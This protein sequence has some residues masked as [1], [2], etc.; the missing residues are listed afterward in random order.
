MNKDYILKGKTPEFTGA[1]EKLKY[2]WDEFVEYKKLEEAK[3]RSAIIK[4]NAA[5]KEYHSSMGSGDYRATKPKLEKDENDLLEKGIIPETQGWAERAKLWFYGHG[6]KLHPETGKCIFTKAQ[7]ATP[8][9]ELQKIMEEVEA[10]E[11]HQTERRTSCHAP[12]GIQN[13]VDE[14]E[15]QKDPFR[16][17]MGFP[18]AVTLIEAG[19][20]KRKRRQ[21]G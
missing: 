21:A 10:G 13:T 17:S 18:T 15:A 14:H 8:L 7:L 4:K 11:F 16:G 3:K 6:G 5:K 12:S 1:N 2:H 9:A 20:G 19:G